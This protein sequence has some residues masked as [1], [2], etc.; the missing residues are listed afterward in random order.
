MSEPC[1][2]VG[3]M[4]SSRGSLQSI[5]HSYAVPNECI[6]PRC[7]EGETRAREREE[8]ENTDIERGEIEMYLST[9]NK[10]KV[11]YVL[12]TKRPPPDSSIFDRF[13]S[14]NVIT[15]CTK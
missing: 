15:M 2:D 6:V 9:N 7:R 11:I 14:E 10:D 5:S 13:G 4:I 3:A 8:K 1:E 12:F